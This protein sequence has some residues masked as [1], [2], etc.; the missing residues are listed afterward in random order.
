V[1]RIAVILGTL[2]VISLSAGCAS[3]FDTLTSKRFR[4]KP[5]GTMFSSEDPMTV[6]RNNP[7]GED[8]ARAMLRMKEPAVNGRSEAE[9][10][11]ALQ[12]LHAAAT[13]DTSPWV[14]IAA[15]EALGKFQDPRAIP[16]L[17]Q[18]FHTASGTTVQSQPTSPTPEIDQA[19]LTRPARFQERY[20]LN[21]PQGFPSDQV[22]NIRGRA[23]EALAKSRHP[24]A[25]AFLAEV[26]K[27]RGQM[28]NEDQTARDFVRQRAV[29]GLGQMR[30]KESV[31]A[32]NDVLAAEHNK[33]V[34]LT[35]LAHAG[36]VGLTGKK[37]PANPE[38]WSEVVQ[39]G[40]YDVVPEPNGI[41]RAIGFGTP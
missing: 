3:T 24:D 39:A 4:E 30:H 1:P 8:R 40:N 22:M 2:S 10:D 23:V 25:V 7:D 12:M 38:Q 28:L 33:D 34:T 26:A 13:A 19:S 37:L 16:S 31:V 21:G 18:A 41:Q 14:R 27:G 29:A 15:I 11:E 6:L 9:Q 35:N 5:F 32:L 20:G 17:T 36:L